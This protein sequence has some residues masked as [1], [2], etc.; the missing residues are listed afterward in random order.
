MV[1]WQGT[2]PKE[3]IA[4]FVTVYSDL[5]KRARLWGGLMFSDVFRR[6]SSRR[7]GGSCANSRRS[8]AND[9]G[10]V[11]WI[12]ALAGAGVS[13]PGSLEADAAALGGPGTLA[14][15]ADPERPLPGTCF[16]SSGGS[17]RALA[18]MTRAGVGAAVSL[19]AT[20]RQESGK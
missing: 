19:S 15:G 1:G 14:V 9:P 18:A 5:T 20:V 2:I 17:C 4:A 8:V 12:G 7:R 10:E 3:S 13:V 11:T 16:R 6:R